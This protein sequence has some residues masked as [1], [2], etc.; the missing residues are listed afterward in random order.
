MLDIFYKWKVSF[1]FVAYSLWK[2]IN[3]FL[4][5]KLLVLPVSFNCLKFVLRS[6]FRGFVG[7]WLLNIEKKAHWDILNC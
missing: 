1:C 2:E 5:I 6:L 7:I 3:A 4:A